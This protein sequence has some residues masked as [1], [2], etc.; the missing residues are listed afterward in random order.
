MLGISYRFLAALSW[1]SAQSVDM[2]MALSI[3]LA[4]ACRPWTQEK[5]TFEGTPLTGAYL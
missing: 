4:R 1:V 3:E 5:Y 2:P